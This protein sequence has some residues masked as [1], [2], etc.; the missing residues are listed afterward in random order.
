MGE[1]SSGAPLPFFFRPPNIVSK[2]WSTVFALSL[3]HWT[4][5]CVRLGRAL[6]VDRRPPTAVLLD[7]R[8]GPTTLK[9]RVQSR[10]LPADPGTG[11]RVKNVGAVGLL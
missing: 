11:L 7:W 6:S 4:A 10:S 9:R 2:L 3:R 1:M 8:D 5:M